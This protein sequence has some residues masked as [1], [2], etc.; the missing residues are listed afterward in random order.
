MVLVSPK[1]LEKMSFTGLK[2]SMN[3]EKLIKL[4]K[5]NLGNALDYMNIFIY[6]SNSFILTANF[7]SLFTK[8][9]KNHVHTIKNFVW[10]ELKRY[11]RYN[12]EEK[13]FKKLRTRFFLCLRNRG[14]KKHALSKLFRHVTYSQRNKLLNTELPLPNVCQ[15]LTVQEAERRILPEGEETFSLSQGTRK[16]RIPKTQSAPEPSA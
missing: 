9:K 10:G 11:V 3:Y 14:F 16:V 8:N 7:Q 1:R 2:I 5:Y 15:P 6:K 4:T 13:F 12:T